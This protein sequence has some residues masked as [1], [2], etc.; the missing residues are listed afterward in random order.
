MLIYLVRHGQ[1]D[2]NAEARLQGQKDIALNNTGRGQALGNGLKLRR[3]LA[4]TGDFDFVSSPLSR[5][6]ETMELM[7][8]A[9]D[10]PR[11]GFRLDERLVEICFGDWEGSTL[12]EIQARDPARLAERDADKWNFIPPGDRAESYEI[13]SWRVGSWLKSVESPTICTCHGGV[14]RCIFAL[15]GQVTTADAAYMDVPQD[16][17]LRLTDAGLHWL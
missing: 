16:R 6:R 5:T 13:L 3:L 9:M 11:H 10:L 4:S 17:I 12:A 1:T 14:I 8:Q 2:W 7:R 15:I